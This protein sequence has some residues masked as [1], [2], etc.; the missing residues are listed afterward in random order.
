MLVMAGQSSREK[1]RILP[2]L[3]SPVVSRLRKPKMVSFIAKHNKSDQVTIKELIEGGKVT[4]I[5]D[6]V[7]PLRD[8]PEAIRYLGEGHPRAKIVVTV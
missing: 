8:T 4:P 6:R 1:P 5:V 2:L 3:L 7:F